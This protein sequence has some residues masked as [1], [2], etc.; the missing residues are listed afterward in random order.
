MVNSIVDFS[1]QEQSDLDMEYLQY[2][3][4]KYDL[5]NYRIITMLFTLLKK[6]LIPDV[7]SIYLWKVLT[8]IF[9]ATDKVFLFHPKNADIFLISS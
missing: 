6:S 1:L 9:I 7:V 2:D 4:I 8:Y 5:Q 3:V